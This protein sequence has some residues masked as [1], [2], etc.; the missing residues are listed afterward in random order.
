[1]ECQ[2]LTFDLVT[3]FLIQVSTYLINNSKCS[4]EI[5]GTLYLLLPRNSQEDLNLGNEMILERCF[6]MV[7]FNDLMQISFLYFK[8]NKGLL[9][10]NP[11]IYIEERVL[12]FIVKE[13]S[14]VYFA[15]LAFFSERTMT[16]RS[17]SFSLA[18]R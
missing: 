14:L 1:M 16:M 17:R 6:F 12:F 8:L 4:F 9:R 18:V 3:S 7:L 5:Q 2:S 10:I 13:E 15:K 11:N